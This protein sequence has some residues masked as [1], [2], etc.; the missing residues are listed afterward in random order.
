MLIYL[1]IIMTLNGQDYERRMPM[2]T[3]ELCWRNAANIFKQV[4]EEHG[5]ELTDLGVGCVFKKEGDPA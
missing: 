1:V 2:D 4:R 5:E 3:E